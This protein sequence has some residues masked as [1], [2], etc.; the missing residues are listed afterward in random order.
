MLQGVPFHKIKTLEDLKKYD[1]LYKEVLR[2]AQFESEVELG[3]NPKSLDQADV[4]YLSEN[5]AGYINDVYKLVAKRLNNNKWLVKTVKIIE[6]KFL[7]SP[8]SIKG[9]KFDNELFKGSKGILEDYLKEKNK[10][11]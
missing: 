3:V 8:D 6:E 2:V 11:S 5:D 10:D 9:V 7:A 4:T 1:A